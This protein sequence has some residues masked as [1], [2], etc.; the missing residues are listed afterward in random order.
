MNKIRL[1]GLLITAMLPSGVSRFVYRRFFGYQIGQNVRIGFSVIDARE[2]EIGDN[3]TI[4]HFNVFT[5][6]GTLTIGEC[7]RVGLFN[8][9]RG[10]ERVSIGRYCEIIRLNE[11]NS[12]PDPLISNPARPEF[13]LGDG[14]VITASHKID[15][16]DRVE[17]GKC[18]ILG[19]RNSS[20]WTH[21]RQSTL[22]VKI[23]AYSY[24]GSELRFAPGAEIPEHCVVGIGSVVTGK[25]VGRFL[26]IAGVPAKPIKELDDEG[27]RLTTFK[28]RPDLPDNF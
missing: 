22:P 27:K 21:N 8:I 17:L 13:L 2:C 12:I 10:G 20:I 25:I 5:G 4:G 23:G 18:V 16:T 11:I 26:L 6:T 15:F 24:L 14:S 9:I 28:T 7:T 3:V 1:I 19:G